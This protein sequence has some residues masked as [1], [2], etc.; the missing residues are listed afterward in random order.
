MTAGTPCPT[1]VEISPTVTPV[2]AL[3]DWIAQGVLLQS[4]HTIVPQHICPWYPHDGCQPSSSA[5]RKK[6]AWPCVHLSL[7]QPPRL[8]SLVAL[9]IASSPLCCWSP[10]CQNNSDWSRNEKVM[11]QRANKWKPP[12][13]W[14][15]YWFCI[16][17][18]N[19]FCCLGKWDL[20]Q[21]SHKLT[22]H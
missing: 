19:T 1:S 6:I 11:G 9:H 5:R 3:R 18:A 8:S 15:L 17:E 2:E 4:L 10:A 13:T 12:L 14:I 20:K 22:L 7:S 16:L 21:F